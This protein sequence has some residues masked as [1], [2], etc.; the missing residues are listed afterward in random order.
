MNKIKIMGVLNITP[1][2]F[3]DGD[4]QYLDKDYLQ[5]KVNDLKLAEI[6]DVGCESSR[7]G[8]KPL[9]VNSELKR[10][11]YLID[12]VNFNANTVLSIDTYK[13]EVAK[14]ALTNGFTYVNDI[15]AG[16]FDSDKMFQVI[17]DYNSSIILVHMKGN[18][19]DMQKNTEYESILDNMLYFFEKRIKK[20]LDFG[21]C[22]KNIIIDPGI[23]FGKTFEDNFKIIKNIEIFKSLGHE[24]L[25]GLSRKNFLTY[26]NDS[27]N[28]RLSATIAMNA[29]SILNGA[30]IVRVHDVLENIKMI[31]AINQYQKC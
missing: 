17:S 4:S 7:P 26:K 16:Q 29:V 20:A 6:I 3:Y 5:S 28:D 22:E 24:V 31:N 21:I 11:S 23:G 2:S 12:G 13:H 8:S 25:I 14:F 10:L 30:D 19:I 18:P 1:D 27:P 15:Y 9:D